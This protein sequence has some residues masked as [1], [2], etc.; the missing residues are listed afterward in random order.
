M[1]VW[2]KAAGLLV[3]MGLAGS[4]AARAEWLNLCDR[5]AKVSASQQ[6]KLFR[7]GAIIKR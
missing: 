1:T 7:F 6:D 3:V 4:G 2:R 5:Q